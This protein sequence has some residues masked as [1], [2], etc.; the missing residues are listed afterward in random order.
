MVSSA[1]YIYIYLLTKIKTCCNLKNSD[2]IVAELLFTVL[3]TIP[4]C[5]FMYV[6]L[7]YFFFFFFRRLATFN[8][9]SMYSIHKRYENPYLSTFLGE[10]IGLSV[11]WL[12]WIVGAAIASVSVG[13]PLQ[14]LA[15]SKTLDRN[16]LT[17][18]P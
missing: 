7:I 18:P 9:I 4:W 15:F 1:I 8:F 13:I 17:P 16:T 12:F 10:I 14:P 5:I 3:I 2:P 6:S 11:L